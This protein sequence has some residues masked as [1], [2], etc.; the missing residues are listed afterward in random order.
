MIT[1]NS[2]ADGTAANSDTIR[3]PESARDSHSCLNALN[4]WNVANY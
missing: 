1:T 2:G 4:D 3:S